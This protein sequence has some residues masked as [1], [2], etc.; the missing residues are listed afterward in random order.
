MD[1]PWEAL[2][3]FSFIVQGVDRIQAATVWPTST[4]R[5]TTMPFTGE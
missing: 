2:S 1:V 4:L 3:N 5:D